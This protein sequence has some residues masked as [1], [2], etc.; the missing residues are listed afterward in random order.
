[1]TKTIDHLFLGIHPRTGMK[2]V[3]I[4]FNE[5]TY[6]AMVSKYFPSIKYA[7]LVDW[8]KQY[9]HEL[10]RYN[11]SHVAGGTEHDRSKKV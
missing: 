8:H 9:K 7:D 2:D 1:M 5:T 10:I 11:I 6:V 3:F 4:P